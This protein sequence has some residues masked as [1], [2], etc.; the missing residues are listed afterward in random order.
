MCNFLAA[1]VN[2]CYIRL[3]TNQK[4]INRLAPS[5]SSSLQHLGGRGRARPNGECGSTSL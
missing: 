4:L 2:I 5:G 3:Y 1:A